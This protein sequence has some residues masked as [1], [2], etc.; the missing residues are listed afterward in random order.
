MS[1]DTSS[2]LWVIIVSL[3]IPVLVEA[4]TKVN[5]HAKVKAIIAATTNLVVAVVWAI[6]DGGGTISRETLTTFLISWSLTVVSYLGIWKPLGLPGAIRPGF[7]IGPP[8]EDG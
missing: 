6:W 5:A 2:S 1:I 7:G 4:A 3:V 8:S